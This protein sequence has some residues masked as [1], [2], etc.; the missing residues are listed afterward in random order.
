[1]C[2]CHN[3]SCRNHRNK[4]RYQQLQDELLVSKDLILESLF[5]V[6]KIMAGKHFG[7]N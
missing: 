5:K 1:M 3:D 6:Y 4:N 7:D 2:L